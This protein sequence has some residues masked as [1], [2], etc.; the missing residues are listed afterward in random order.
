MGQFSMDKK[1]GYGEL[2]WNEGR[3]VYK[4]YFTNDMKNGFGELTI[5]GLV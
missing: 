2:S 1:N 5:N 3:F 4:G